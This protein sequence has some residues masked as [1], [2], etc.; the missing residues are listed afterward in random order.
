[1]AFKMKNP[2]LAKA[3]SKASSPMQA[4]YSPMKKKGPIDKLR[5]K[6]SNVIT[7]MKNQPGPSFKNVLGAGTK[8][9]LQR[10]GELLDG[11]NESI[12]G[13]YTKSKTN[14]ELYDENLKK[15]EKNK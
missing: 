7:E 8:V 11:S 10:F 13:S 12:Y 9:A 4:N 15:L 5:S 6:I 1:M 2:M 3:A 14:K